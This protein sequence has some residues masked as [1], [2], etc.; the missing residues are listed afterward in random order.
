MLPGYM[1][2]PVITLLVKI[3]P[4]SQVIETI[5]ICSSL[6][7]FGRVKVNGRIGTYHLL[8]L[9]RRQ[10]TKGSSFRGVRL[11]LVGKNDCF[12]FLI[13]IKTVAEDAVDR[14]SSFD[15]ACVEEFLP[16]L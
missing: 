11:G 1:V 5:K 15:D 7:L 2:T 13:S 12:G 8:L 6:R 4:Q 14:L 9:T 16:W 3:E 10:R